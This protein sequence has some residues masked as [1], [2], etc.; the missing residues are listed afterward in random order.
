[1]AQ[2]AGAV[3]DLGHRAPLLA[4]EE[5]QES[6]P[7]LGLDLHLDELGLLGQLVDP[8]QQLG[9][10][11]LP[12]LD[13]LD[14]RA[15]GLGPLVAASL[16]LGG[17]LLDR[18]LELP[19]PLRGLVDGLGRVVDLRDHGRELALVGHHALLLLEVLELDLPLGLLPADLRDF[20]S[21]RGQLAL[22][23]LELL[24]PQ[25]VGGLQLAD[26]GRRRVAL[27]DRLGD[28]VVHALQANQQYEIVFFLL[29]LSPRFGCAPS[30][31][32]P[33]GFEPGTDRL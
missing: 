21:V 1:M 20:L 5:A 17:D 2:R 13:H 19:A 11:L 23:G 30:A 29:T 9:L 10:P 22:E 16:D 26:L 4:L 25:A 8:L 12:G 18:G 24:V 32:G 27:G 28:G 31:M 6:R 33:P 14:L 7:V 3:D 15:L